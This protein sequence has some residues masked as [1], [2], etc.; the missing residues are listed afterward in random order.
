[1]QFPGKN[2]ELGLYFFNCPF[3]NSY[4]SQ[5]LKIKIPIVIT[6]PQH[7]S[8]FVNFLPNT[9]PTKIIDNIFADL[10]RHCNGKLTNL[11]A[12]LVNK[13]DT[14]LS[15]PYINESLYEIGCYYSSYYLLA[16]E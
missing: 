15:E 3:N 10:V 2:H 13:V 1:M 7:S 8:Y 11:S 9:N 14:K 4:T 16:S 6:H 5:R 12:V